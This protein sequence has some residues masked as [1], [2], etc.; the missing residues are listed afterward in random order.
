ME[1][2]RTA[3]LVAKLLESWGIEVHRGVGGTG[4]VGVL[5]QGNAPARIGLRADMDA[6]PIEEATGAIYKSKSQGKM[7]ACG[8]DA[9]AAMLVGAAEMLADGPETLPAS[10]RLIFQPAEE[11]GTGARAMIE[12]GV[13]QDVGAIFG[14]HVDGH[15]QTGVIAVVEGTVNACSDAFRISIRGLQGHA[16]RPH[17]TVDAVVVDPHRH[18]LTKT[19]EGEEADVDRLT[20]LEDLEVGERQVDR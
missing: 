11:L 13:L 14:G 1:E 16:A 3:E 15:L 12:A 20:F 18:A 2:H 9:H 4:V 8:H 19:L 6:L 17:E 7:H 10:V 5:R